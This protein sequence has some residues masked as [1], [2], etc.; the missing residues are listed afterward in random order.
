MGKRLRQQRRGKGSNAYT[1]PPKSGRFDALLPNKEPAGVLEGEV[2]EFIDNPLHNAALMRVKYFDNSESVLIAP[3]GIYIGSKVQEGPGA[4]INIGNVLRLSEI[5]DGVFVCNAE[6][7]PGDGGKLA[8]AAGAY[9]TVVSHGDGTVTLLLPSKQTIE[10]SGRCRAEIGVAS[11]GGTVT[12]PL[13]KAGKSHYIMH[14]INTKWPVNRGVKMNPVDHPFGGKQHHKGYSSMT[15]RNAPPGAKVGSI[16]AS[17]IG[18][19]K[20]G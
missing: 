12:E 15:S 7:T 3:E 9:A 11:G 1:K 6:L 5:P 10:L 19:K 18:R 8:R 14:A 2:M 4:G 16:A 17:R 13:M 20:R